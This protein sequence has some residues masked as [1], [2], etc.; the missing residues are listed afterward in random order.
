MEYRTGMVTDRPIRLAVLLSGSGRTL[1]NLAKVIAG[2]EL[3]AE[4]LVVIA[5]RRSAL[6]LERAGRLNLPRQ[7]VDRKSYQSPTA[8]SDVLF[9][10]IR[11]AEVDLVCLC[12]FLSLL[13]IPEDFSGRVINIHPALLPEF[14]GKGM[15]GHYVHEA[16]LAAGRTVSGCTVHHADKTYDTGQT[17]LHRTCEV[18]SEDTP[19]SLAARVF[20]QEC[21]AYPE[22]IRKIAPKILAE[23][24]AT[25]GG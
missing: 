19:E 14:G 12:G 16:V 8:F 25:K 13:V 22:A 2:G 23:A 21:I 18:M 10:T 24:R 17:I 11:K 4:I 9:K 20:E 1:Q 6:G 15:Y 3:D 5:S 7:L